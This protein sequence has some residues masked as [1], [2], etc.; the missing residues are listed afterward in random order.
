MRQY[1]TDKYRIALFEDRAFVECSADNAHHYDLVYFDQSQY[2]LPTIYGIQVFQG[3][4]LIKSAVI[5]SI[6]GGKAI[7]D[8]S[9]II[10]SDRLLVCCSDTIFCLSIPDLTLL[11]RTQADQAT[12]F[13]IYK[14]DDSYIVRGE[15][16]ISRLNREGKVLWQRGGRDILTTQEGIG[17]FEIHDDH[18]LATDW[19][20]YRYKI[21][22][23]GNVL[24]EYKVDPQR[25]ARDAKAWW[26]FWG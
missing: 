5:G 23:D 19:Q 24:E 16:D 22:F 13:E 7:H 25:G 15:M 6:G 20:Y 3:D 12:C 14:Y 10:E 21:D 11:W 26:K 2:D 8:T 18:I 1:N 4:T 9:T 17:D